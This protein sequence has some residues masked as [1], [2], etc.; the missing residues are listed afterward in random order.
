M[1]VHLT[2]LIELSNVDKDIDSFEPRIAKIRAELIAVQEKKEAHKKEIN[3]KKDDMKDAKLKMQ[4]ND[5]HLAELADKLKDI[6]RKSSAVKTEKEMKS[7]QLEEEIA[8][9]QITFANEEIER[10]GKV[11]DLKEEEIKN[12]EEEI[13]KL[14]EEAKEI[15]HNVQDEMKAIEEERKKVFSEKEKLIQKMDQKI[16]SFYEKIRRWAE[17]TTV[18]P[19]RKQAC[20]GCFMVINDKTYADVIKSDDIIT[21]PHCGRIL[22]IKPPEE[23]KSKEEAA[24]EET[25][26]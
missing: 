2:H 23:E 9:E 8:K 13:A 20:G 10:L 4:K 24:T 6:E 5:L 17:N 15:E 25:E 16:I 1:N 19:V 12:L 26:G 14:D 3:L 21:C 22:Y 7:L 11:T 18:V